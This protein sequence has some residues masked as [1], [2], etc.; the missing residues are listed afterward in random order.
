MG[1][2]YIFYLKWLKITDSI[3]VIIKYEHLH[4]LKQIRPFL[5]LSKNLT[6]FFQKRG[7][8]DRE[9]LPYFP[10]RDDGLLIW[11]QIRSYVEEYVSM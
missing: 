11:Q 3:T 4:S 6:I 10:Y 1:Y 9:K 7:V 2:Y 8:D 5:R